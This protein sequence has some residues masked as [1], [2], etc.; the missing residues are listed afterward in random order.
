[1]LEKGPAFTNR[2]PQSHL[3][4]VIKAGRSFL[5]RL[6]DLSK[7]TKQPDHFVRLNRQSRSELEWLHL[8]LVPIALAAGT[9][10]KQWSGK[11]IMA[12]CDNEAVVASLNK[13]DSREEECMHLMR[14][15]AFFQAKFNFTLYAQHIKG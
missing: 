14:Y 2:S 8:E 13:G 4:K 3:C 10:G 12:Y 15:L 1:M 5:R 11:N 7:V 6:I 9:W